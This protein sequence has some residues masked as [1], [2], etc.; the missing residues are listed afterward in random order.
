MQFE[1][2]SLVERKLAKIPCEG[3]DDIVGN[4]TGCYNKEGKG[5]TREQ[6]KRSIEIRQK[7]RKEKVQI[8]FWWGGG[9]R[10]ITSNQHG[11]FPC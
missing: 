3:S 10:L 9:S 4:K 7:N 1:F 8:F 11:L 2:V 5:K 6:E